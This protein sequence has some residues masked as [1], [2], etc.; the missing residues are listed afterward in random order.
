MAKLIITRG[1][2]GSGKSTWARSWVSD[3]PAHRAEVN[4]DHLRNML[5][6]G[7]VNQEPQVNAARDAMIDSLLRRNVS[8]V[9]SDTNLPQRVARDIAAIGYRAGAG[10]EV[11]DLTNVPLETCLERNFARTDK[12]PVP[13]DWIIDQHKRFIAGKGYPLRFPNPGVTSEDL[14][15]LYVPDSSLPPAVIFDI[16]GTL[17]LKGARDA[18]D[19]SRVHEDRPNYPVIEAASQESNAG[20]LIIIVSG[21][22]KGCREA[23]ERWLKV[24]FR[25][26]DGLIP[27]LGPYMR[28]VGNGDKDYIHKLRVFNDYIRNSF[29]V[30]RVYD[31]RDQVVRLWR[32]GLGLPCFQVNYGAF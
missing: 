1:L 29:Y 9:C 10:V 20:N 14:A 12:D 27:Y 25:D 5:H 23:T 3:D 2:P 18:F 11:K 32:E 21:R 31:D 13:E 19:E 22:T 30:R 6:G 8:V 15:E 17:A 26:S 16:D 4:R 7:Y 28:P 24:H